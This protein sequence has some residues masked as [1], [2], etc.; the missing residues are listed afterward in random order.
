MRNIINSIL[1]PTT[2]LPPEPQPVAEAPVSPPPLPPHVRQ[3]LAAEDAARAVAAAGGLAVEA[4]SK[5]LEEATAAVV[6]DESHLAELE[7]MLEP[8]NETMLDETRT[9]RRLSQRRTAVADA[10]A[11]LVGAEARWAESKGELSK[12]EGVRVQAE[13]NHEAEVMLAEID[14]FARVMEERHQAHIE[15]CKKAGGVSTTVSKILPANRWSGPEDGFVG[16]A[17]HLF[18]RRHFGA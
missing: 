18:H 14:T 9:R 13:L 15:R 12:A 4:A 10:E 7:A 3:A 17:S 16:I 11:A 1:K 2:P 5:R 8:T 6:A